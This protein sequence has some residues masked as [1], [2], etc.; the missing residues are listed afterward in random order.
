MISTIPRATTSKYLTHS[1]LD[2]Q[3]VSTVS[4]SQPL[5]TLC[6]LPGRYSYREIHL[7][8]Y[9]TTKAG[10]GG[11][12][13]GERS[14]YLRLSFLFEPPL[15]A[16][17]A[18]SSI[19][20][21]DDY[22]VR[23]ILRWWRLHTLHTYIHPYSYTQYKEQPLPPPEKKKKGMHL[24]TTNHTSL[25]ALHSSIIQQSCDAITFPIL[26]IP[27][28]LI[29]KLAPSISSLPFPSPLSPLSTATQTNTTPYHTARL[30]PLLQTNH[31]HHHVHTRCSCSCLATKSASFFVR[32]GILDTTWPVG[33]GT[34]RRDMYVC[35]YVC[36]YHA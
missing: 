1:S 4:R 17:V 20:K 23:F 36:P 8:S 30:H 28:L 29:I 15:F 19:P 31:H 7:Y 27:G 32:E 14:S 22:C 2:Y 34:H 11:W 13:V 25:N 18:R 33:V 6:L 9:L 21:N 26:F 3:R 16:T 12:R 24:S 5:E 10:K 35:I